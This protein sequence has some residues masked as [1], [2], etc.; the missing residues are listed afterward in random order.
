MTHDQGVTNGKGEDEG[1]EVSSDRPK[2]DYRSP[3]T[4]EPFALARKIENVLVALCLAFIVLMLVGL[5]W[6]VIYDD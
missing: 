4:K 5:F 1:E 2:L 6:V 3:Q